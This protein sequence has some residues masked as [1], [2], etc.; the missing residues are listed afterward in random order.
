MRSLWCI[1]IGGTVWR[2]VWGPTAHNC[3]PTDVGTDVGMDVGTDVFTDV[4]TD[5]GTDVDMD[6]DTDVDTDPPTD[7]GTDRLGLSKHRTQGRAP[8]PR[9]AQCCAWR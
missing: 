9:R 4:D 3:P 2:T 1:L 7:V 8:S 5:A 6:V